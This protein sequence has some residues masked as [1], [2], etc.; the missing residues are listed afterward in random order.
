[1]NCIASTNRIWLIRL[2]SLLLAVVIC[3][4]VDL[5]QQDE[6]ELAAT[7]RVENLSPGL[8]ITGGQLP[9]VRVRLA[10][11][12]ILLIRYQGFSPIL[13]LECGGLREGVTRFVGLEKGVRVPV[14]IRVVGVVPA[15]VEMKLLK[16]D[17][18][19]R[20]Q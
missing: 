18:G 9:A 13:P 1:M 20:R 8:V 2:L 12:K 3:L 16:R 17:K 15:T 6:A 11:P 4:F 10:G 14:G 7:V 19:G 5:E